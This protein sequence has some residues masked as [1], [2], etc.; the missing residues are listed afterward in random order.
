MQFFERTVMKI[1]T[2]VAIALCIL[3]LSASSNAQITNLTVIGV[4]ANF[5]VTAGD[6]FYWSYNIPVGG[7]AALEIYYDVNGNGSIDQGTDFAFGIFN[8]TDGQAN[9]DNGPGDMDGT[10]NGL[11]VFGQRI[12]LVPG[13]YIMKV[14]NGGSTRSITGVVNALVSPI[15]QIS[16]HVS[17]PSGYSNQHII[18]EARPEQGQTFWDGITD[19]S[20]N[21]TI[22]IGTHENGNT[23]Q[24]R[25]SQNYPAGLVPAMIETTF[26]ISGA[27]YT[28]NFSFTA[29]LAKVAG[30]VKD[31]AGNP[32]F[33]KEVHL[34]G[35]NM[36]KYL[37]SRTDNSGYF[38]LGLLAENL[39]I[40]G[41]SIQTSNNGDQTGSVL[42]AQRQLPVMNSGDSVYRE[43]I[44]YSVNS[45]ITGQVQVNGAPP[46]FRIMILAYNRDTAQA[47]VWCD[48]ATG[49]FSIPVSNKIYDYNVF[50][51][52]I[53]PPYQFTGSV[54]AHPGNSGIILNITTGILPA[55]TVTG[56]VFD[57]GG[58]PL[59][60]K[61]VGIYAPSLP[62]M[63]TGITDGSGFFQIN[64]S[65]SDLERSQMSIFTE[66]QD[67]TG[68][69]LSGA[70]QLPVIHHGDNVYREL[71][72]YSANSYISG[73]VLVDGVPA[74]SSFSIVAINPDSAMAMARTDAGT[75]NFSMPVS[76]KIYRYIV[77]LPNLPPEF[78]IHPVNAQP[79]ETGIVISIVTGQVGWLMVSVPYQHA[80]CSKNSLFNNATSNAFL[81]NSIAGYQTK[82]SM[83]YGLGYWLKFDAGSPPMILGGM[84]MTTVTIPVH[85]G[86]NMIGSISNPVPVSTITSNPPAMVLST[87]F[88]FKA[89]YVVSDTIKPGKGYWVKADQA[90]TLT[91]GSMENYSPQNR[92]RIVPLNELPPSPPGILTSNGVKVPTEF[93]LEQN[94]PNPFNPTT[95]ISFSIPKSTFVSLK[96]FDVL[97]REVQSLVNQQMEPG[98]YFVNVDGTALTTGIYFYRLKTEQFSSVKKFMLMK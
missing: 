17:V 2:Q 39:S 16:G 59:S 76:N 32:V 52:N 47:N 80:D 86:W 1:F 57:E 3:L 81:F 27:N 58:N 50:P 66:F 19:A 24:V 10:A 29:P 83:Q 33:D 94:Y 95:N 23:W 79:G 65:E 26:V 60:N 49:N 63:I 77:T 89:G 51:V 88:A 98:N 20:G 64:L 92:V 87:F 75:G 22:A 72:V 54:T 56:R 7:T 14:S 82:D 62:N 53:G 18:I 91:L 67:V 25:L 8:Q 46:N 85:Q 68:S 73:H 35:P 97:G 31:E 42:Q 41:L 71:T 36:S 78:Q 44:L 15:H 93:K 11:I 6:S 45:Q 69:T 61:G 9:S 70:A 43:L 30:F 5:T 74:V 4:T 13:H 48:S 96:V 37:N 34:S 90:G 12:G 21:Y 55:A 84:P 38:E 40:S 28:V